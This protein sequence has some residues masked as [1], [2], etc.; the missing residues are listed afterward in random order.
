MSTMTGSVVKSIFHDRA[1]HRAHAPAQ[2]LANM[3]LLDS[4]FPIPA[5]G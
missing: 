3:A 1:G 5:H 2:K 4:L